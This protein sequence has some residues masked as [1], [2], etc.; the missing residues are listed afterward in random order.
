MGSSLQ[1]C[2]AYNTVNTSCGL[3]YY[4]LIIVASI[5]AAR[6]YITLLRIYITGCYSV[7]QVITAFGMMYTVVLLVKI[8]SNFHDEQ[9]HCAVYLAAAESLSRVKRE[10]YKLNNVYGLV[11]WSAIVVDRVLDL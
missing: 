5:A 1:Y 11:Q 9:G 3:Q 7:I 4:T 2:T 10:N 6:R 8:Y